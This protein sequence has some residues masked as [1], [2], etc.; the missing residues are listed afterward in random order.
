VKD[1]PYT[2][3]AELVLDILPFVAS[4]EVFALKGGTAINFFIRD[5]PRLSVDID[6]AYLP[7]TEREQALS[8]VTERLR[9]VR[10]ALIGSTAAESV[11]EIPLGNTGMLR[12]L[13]VS[14]RQA[15][16]KIEPNLVIRGVVY[17]PQDLHLSAAAAELFER[18]VEIRALSHAD[19]YGGKICAALDRQ[20]PRDLFDVGLM[21]EHDGFTE[22]TRKAFIVY[23]I[24][25]DRPMVELLDPN[26]QDIEPLYRL[27][28]QGMTRSPV[29][30][31]A[32]TAV[33][34]RL[35]QLI[36]DSLTT[37]ERRF[38]VSMKHG[39]PNWDLLSLPGVENL[40][41]VRWKL[42]NIRKMTPTKRQRALDKLKACLQV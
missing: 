12:G 23:L 24:S 27:E 20:H 9:V 8:D 17:P 16:V 29:T 19:L 4:H 5:L 13:V 31:E 18:A 38:M 35:I 26:R 10:T 1:S 6:L 28:F 37:D 3:Q 22:Q 33:R 2:R 21:L 30:I 14:R 36:Q 42:L 34:E 15:T 41:A 32:L 40:P 11:V 7:V 25:H 39:E